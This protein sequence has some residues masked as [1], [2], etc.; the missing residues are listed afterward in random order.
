VPPA[1]TLLVLRCSDILASKRFYE[2]LGLEFQLEQHGDGPEH[3]SSVVGG[4]VLELY[5]AGRREASICRLGF[6][7]PDVVVAAEAAAAAGGHIRKL[8][9]ATGRALVNDPDGTTV[10]LT[11]PSSVAR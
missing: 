3:W 4:L 8:D 1:L 11:G 2:A 7:V 9:E 5:P 10:E 6:R